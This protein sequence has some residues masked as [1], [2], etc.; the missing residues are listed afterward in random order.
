MKKI[1]VIL[2]VNV[3]LSICIAQTLQAQDDICSPGTLTSDTYANSGSDTSG[4]NTG[5]TTQ[6]GEVFGTEY[7]GEGNSAFNTCE[8]AGTFTMPGNPGPS[9]WYTFTPTQTGQHCFSETSGFADAD[10]QMALFETTGAVCTAGVPDFSQLSILASSDD[11]SATSVGDGG[12][13]Y[14]SNTIFAIESTG[15]AAFCV[16]LTAGTTYYLQITGVALFSTACAGTTC[17]ECFVEFEAGPYT[18]NVV[19]PPMCPIEVTVVGGAGYNE[20]QN[21]QDEFDAAGGFGGFPGFSIADD[22]CL[23]CAAISTSINYGVQP[24]GCDPETNSVTTEYWVESGNAIDPCAGVFEGSQ[25]D[26]NDGMIDVGAYWDHSQADGCSPVY[27]DATFTIVVTNDQVGGVDCPCNNVCTVSEVV[28]VQVSPP[29]IAGYRI[30]PVYN[31][32]TDPPS[33]SVQPTDGTNVLTDPNTG[34][35]IVC[36]V[37]LAPDP[38]TCGGT[39]SITIVDSELQAAAPATD[40][41]VDFTE[42]VVCF[43]GTGDFTVADICSG[44]MVTLAPGAGCTLDQSSVLFGAPNPAYTAIA[45]IYSTDGVNP[46]TTAPPAAYAPIPVGGTADPANF[47]PNLIFTGVQESGCTDKTFSGLDNLTC[48]PITYYIVVTYFGQDF[49]VPDNDPGFIGGYLDCAFE[50]LPVT[51]WPGTMTARPTSGSCTAASMIEIVAADGATICATEMDLAPVAPPADCGMV[52]SENFMYDVTVTELGLDMAPMTCQQSFTG[53]VAGNCVSD[54]CPIECPALAEPM[55]FDYW[56]CEGGSIPAGEGLGALGVDCPIPPTPTCLFDPSTM[57]IYVEAT[58]THTYLSDM[59]WTLQAPSGATTTI[60]PFVCCP[61]SGDDFNQLT[62]TNA[63]VG[64]NFQISGGGGQTPPP[65]TG[66]YDMVEGGA[67]N[68]G[69]LAGEE[70]YS[71]GWNL[72][73]G[74]CVGGDF[75]IVNNVSVTFTDNGSGTSCLANAACVGCDGTTEIAGPNNLQFNGEPGVEYD[76]GAISFNLADNACTEADGAFVFPIP[77]PDAQ[78]PQAPIVNWYDDPVAGNL[79]GSGNI[80][81][82]TDNTV[83][84]WCY[85]AEYVCNLNTEGDCAPDMMCPSTRLE[86]CLHIY[87]SDAGTT[88]VDDQFL[89]CDEPVLFTNVDPLLDFDN[90]V[91]KH[92]YELGYALVAGSQTPVSAAADVDAALIVQAEPATGYT[93]TCTACPGGTTGT[94]AAGVYSVTPFLSIDTYDICTPLIQGA[95]IP[96]TDNPTFEAYVWDYTAEG[97]LN[98]VAV[99]A[100]AFTLEVDIYDLIDPNDGDGPTGGGCEM[101]DIN[102]FVYVNGTLVAVQGGLTDITQIVTFTE[103]DFPLTSNDDVQVQMAFSTA[104]NGCSTTDMDLTDCKFAASVKLMLTATFDATFTDFSEGAAC[105]TF[106]TPAD[107]IILDPICTAEAVTCN[108]D[109]TYSV[110]FTPEGG[111]SALNGA[112]YVDQTTGAAVINGEYQISAPGA[113]TVSPAGSGDGLT[114]GT[115]TGAFTVTYPT[116]VPMYTI[117]IA[118]WDAN[119]VA[120]LPADGCPF[121]ITGMI[122][123]PTDP[124]TTSDAICEGEA[125]GTLTADCGANSIMWFADDGT[126][127]PDLAAGPVA[128]TAD[129]VPTDTAP[130]TYTYYAVCQDALG[131]SSAPIPAT[132]TI[133]TLGTASLAV[134]TLSCATEDLNLNPSP[135]GGIYSGAGA[136]FVDAATGTIVTNYKDLMDPNVVYD[137]TYTVAGAG[138]CDGE[139]TIQISF[140]SDCAADGG[141]F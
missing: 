9:N 24:T 86:V 103:A 49:A 73:I 119:A 29:G 5:S 84:D 43:E 51:V 88:T 8:G 120:L 36:D 53:M 89:C 74:D 85:Y 100:S 83:G 111:L 122:T 93:P 109:G 63:P 72:I 125:A 105:N 15:D 22:P 117:D 38:L 129:F 52:N 67:I 26:D 11:D 2:F 47:D 80:F 138:G 7:N 61:Q 98:D 91:P 107:I 1:Y 126:A 25:L 12:T 124:T 136:A 97:T 66:T 50:I 141:R 41:C 114:T 70:I 44:D 68:W 59:T 39:A 115:G 40:V 23:W 77:V 54:P 101:T 135:T 35:E 128:T 6:T 45:F 121:Q 123:L 20:C 37:I 79:V 131:C 33:Y 81:A 99:P 132:Y 17:N 14:S 27:Y 139:V 92:T 94:L 60:F 108:P 55:V 118:N 32:C 57:F 95:N 90:A 62:F 71:A 28:T 30:T 64:N 13:L 106:G 65:W 31:N 69:A 75:G 127:M 134:P 42:D 116:S 82:P 76:S 4:D 130:G 56:L 34:A 112:A 133:N 104:G 18:I 87:A 102:V 113:V 16:N 3:F 140:V 19:E 46:S 48:D 96:Q 78:M 110:T 137:L 10:H 58:G 21:I